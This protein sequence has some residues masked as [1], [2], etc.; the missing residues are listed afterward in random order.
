[1]S[2]STIYLRTLSQAGNVHSNL[3]V[4]A[5]VEEAIRRGEGLLTDNG[6][7]VVRTG[8]FTGRSPEDKYIDCGA[9]TDHQIDWG[10][11]NQPFD[12]RKFERIFGRV[13]AHL[14][15]RDLFVFDGYA[16]ASEE[17]RL[18]VRVITETAWQSLFARQLFIRPHR[19]ELVHFSP[20]FTVIAAGRFHAIPEIDGTRSETFIIIDFEKKVCLIGGTEY[21]GEIKTSVFTILN[22]LLP[23]R[24]V[25]PMHCSANTGIHG[26]TALFF[27]LSGT[28]K[29]TLSAAPDRQ[30]IGD[31]EHGWSDRGIFNFEGGCYAKCIHLDR[32]G[33]PQIWQAIRYGAVVENVAM[34][35]DTRMVA[36]DDATLT[37][38][39]R[40]TY[41]LEYIPNAV[42]SA[43]GGH[44]ATIFFLTADAYGVL[45][46]VS[47]LTTEQAM[48][49][50]LSGYTS[51][52]GAMERGVGPPQV[53]FS[54]C[55]GAPFIPLHP[56]RYAEMLRDRLTRHKTN[57]F[58][59]NTG[60]TGGGYGVG[61]RIDLGATRRIVRAAMSGALN[62]VPMMTD[63]V[64]G[65]RYPTACPGVPPELLQPRTSWQDSA[66]YDAA[67]RDLAARFI[68]NFKKFQSV[69]EAI[70]LAGPCVG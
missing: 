57:C 38:N 35:D 61:G 5:L 12:Q 22:Y 42:P 53:T 27:G 25:L 23:L 20:E 24:N 58:L 62:D 6:A 68:E 18:P 43:T 63:P 16:G 13:L 32:E 34:A 41:P 65:L 69:P 28:G 50:F 19:E 31:D 17:Y 55:F 60:W 37:E 54:T 47:K 39:T 66:A 36:F 29:T 67:S 46:P 40:A 64:F 44:P 9:L 45:P 7:F 49:H 30:L 33:E 1:M 59:V 10:K 15:G 51:K 56:I 8:K 70:A 26:D 14:A 21:A 3:N 48:Y 11:V 4:S 2:D 52:L